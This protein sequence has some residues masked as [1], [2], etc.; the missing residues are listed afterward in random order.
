M[1]D[2]AA[3]AGASLA[4]VAM[5]KATPREA[6]A[7]ARGLGASFPQVGVISVREALE[8]V[9][10][11]FDQLSLA[12]RACAAIVALAG[13]LVLAGAVAARA[14]ARAREAATLA[15]LGATR[16]QILMLYAVEYGASAWW[17]ARPA[18]PPGVLPPGW[19]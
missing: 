4:H 6:Q 17:P 10:G 2:P 7:A 11:L 1:L 19:W 9:A 14:G 5:A 16:A 12:I 13:L 15:A 8:A 18:W 3:L